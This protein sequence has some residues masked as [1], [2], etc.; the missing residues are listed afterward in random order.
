MEHLI[1]NLVLPKL[2]WLSVA[3]VHPNIFGRFSHIVKQPKYKYFPGFLIAS[4]FQAYFTV[5]MTCVLI[6]PILSSDR[7]P[8]FNMVTIIPLIGCL[9]IGSIMVS[10]D[11]IFLKFNVT[12]GLV[13]ERTHR[14]YAE[15][16]KFEVQKFEKKKFKY[17]SILEKIG[18][19]R[20]DKIVSFSVLY[21]ILAPIIPSF[22]PFLNPKLEPTYFLLK[23]FALSSEDCLKSYAILSIRSVIIF[24]LFYQYYTI[25]LQFGVHFFAE[26]YMSLH[27]LEGIA[28]IVTRDRNQSVAQFQREV[29]LHRQLYIILGC[30]NSILKMHVSMTIFMLW[31]LGIT[32]SCLIIWIWKEPT[33][34]LAFFVAYISFDA[35][36]YTILK[37]L[38]PRMERVRTASLKLTRQS[39][40]FIRDRKTH[41]RELRSLLPT[42]VQLGWFEVEQSSPIGGVTLIEL[43]NFDRR[44]ELGKFTRGVMTCFA[45]LGKLTNLICRMAHLK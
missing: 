16:V 9:L 1:F 37:I 17:K 12:M 7:D 19:P 33:L 45:N 44:N 29:C 15:C 14:L 10:A 31:M 20:M 2:Q 42:G 22:V 36:V 38:V 34:N 28:P 39:L 3:Y 21:S 18:A 4:A 23:A 11:L 41:T 6:H 25:A 24:I 5:H 40:G 32:S 35:V 8:D 27:I 43:H 30:Y 13:L 26:M